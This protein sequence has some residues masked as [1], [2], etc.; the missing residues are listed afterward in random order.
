V[1]PAPA[2]NISNLCWS[3]IVQPMMPP[4]AVAR[5]SVRQKLFHVI[6]RFSLSALLSPIRAL[7]SPPSIPMIAAVTMGSMFCML[8][9]LYLSFSSWF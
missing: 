7:A 9:C 4:I 8:G 2:K 1:P 5:M 3:G 6:L